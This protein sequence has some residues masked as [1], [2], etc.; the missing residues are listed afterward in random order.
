MRASAAATRGARGVD[1]LARGSRRAAARSRSRAASSEARATSRR[2]RASSRAF[3]VPEPAASRPSMRSRSFCAPAR[4]AS[5]RVDLGRG[6]AHVLV[7]GAGE[8]Q[9][10]LGVG[11]G[12]LGAGRVEREPGVGRVEARDLL[13][14][15]RRR[16]PRRR[17]SVS[18]RAGDL[19]SRRSPRSPRRGRTRRSWR[20]CRRGGSRLS[21]ST[22]EHGTRRRRGASWAR[23][24][25]TCGT[26]TGAAG[27]RRAA[28]AGGRGGVGREAAQRE[29]L[30]V[31]QE[32]REAPASAKGRPCSSAARAPRRLGGAKNTSAPTRPKCMS[33]GFDG[34]QTSLARAAR[35]DPTHDADDRDAGGG[36][37]RA[38]R[39]STAPRA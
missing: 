2:V 31:A 19:R 14:G 4:S 29:L 25:R 16:R 18:S 26:G 11:Q 17:T 15:A 27:R 37:P 12:A 21:A 13:A 30:E 9:P 1:L 35:G 39:R 22:G 23:S 32:L 38:R 3:V 20:P 7:A 28:A 10:Q 33:S 8:A 34:P 5:A 36:P 6:L 24:F